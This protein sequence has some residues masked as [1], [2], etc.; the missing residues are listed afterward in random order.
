MRPLFYTI[1]MCMA[2]ISLLSACGVGTTS[3]ALDEQP[4]SFV[5]TV[6]KAP[7]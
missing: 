1:F 7:T 4:T 6:Y 3:P 5:I 2:A